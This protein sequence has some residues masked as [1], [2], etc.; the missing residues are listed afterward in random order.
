MEGTAWAKAQRCDNTSSGQIKEN[1]V[2]QGA[3]REDEPG[4]RTVKCLECHAGLLS[5]ILGVKS[6]SKQR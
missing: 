1:I 3:V 2:I 4:N 5:F 6:V